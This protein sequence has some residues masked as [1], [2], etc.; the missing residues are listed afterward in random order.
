MA[1][2]N[3]NVYVVTGPLYLPRQEP[4]G[5]LY[6]KYQVIGKNQVSVPTHFFKVTKRFGFVV[7]VVVVDLFYLKLVKCFGRVVDV[8]AP[9]RF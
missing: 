1:K 4:D 5:K 2:R 7:V 3:P 9:T 6:V 8:C